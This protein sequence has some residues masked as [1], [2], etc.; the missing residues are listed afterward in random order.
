MLMPLRFPQV[1]VSHSVI[2]AQNLLLLVCGS[3]GGRKSM[4]SDLN[5]IESECQTN[6]VLSI[7][8]TIE[9]MVTLNS[10]VEH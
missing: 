9:Q 10:A 7:V 8:E 6:S 3:L 5:L 4:T 2:M 1:G